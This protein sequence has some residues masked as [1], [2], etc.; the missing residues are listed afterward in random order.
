MALRHDEMCGG[1]RGPFPSLRH[2]AVKWSCIQLLK[3]VPGMHVTDEPNVPTPT[4]RNDNRWQRESRFIIEGSAGHGRD[5][6]DYDVAVISAFG[7]ANLALMQEKKQGKTRTPEST[8]LE[9]L[10]NKG[11]DK[12]KRLPDVLTRGSFQPLIF[13]T[14]GMMAASTWEA[15]N[16]WKKQAASGAFG[17]MMN[18]ISTSLIRSRART[19]LVTDM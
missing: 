7:G 19:D 9:I 14:G 12:R 1:S 18:R 8:L 11:A 10:D 6:T 13:S 15:I 17:F 5:I 16:I 3:T 2:N 4:R